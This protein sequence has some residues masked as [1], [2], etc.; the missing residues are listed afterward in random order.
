MVDPDV[1]KTNMK[2]LKSGDVE[3]EEIEFHCSKKTFYVNI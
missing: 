3:I 1:K 2:F